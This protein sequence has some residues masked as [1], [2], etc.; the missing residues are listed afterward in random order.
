MQPYQP[1]LKPFARSLRSNMT[2]AEQ[3]LWHLLRRKQIHGLQ[4]YRQKPL[5][6]YIVDFYCPQARLVIEIDGSQH[7]DEQN[8]HE[9]QV[10]TQA[11]NALGLTVLRFDN[12][13]VLLETEEVLAQI[14]NIIQKQI[15]PRPPLNKG[16]NQSAEDK[17]V[18]SPSAKTNTK[19]IPPLEKGGQGGFAVEEKKNG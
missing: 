3:K 6:N 16:G 4:F 7:F 15:P 1:T 19:E 10:R 17:S 9:D 11:L 12:R 2:D 18:A 5:L 8:R 14:Y 13:Q